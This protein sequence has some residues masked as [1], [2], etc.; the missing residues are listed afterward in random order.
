D[1]GADT[2][3]VNDRGQTALGA[4]VFRQSAASVNAL[5][6]AG[7]DPALGGPSAR[8]VATFF[9]LPEMVALLGSAG[10]SQAE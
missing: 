7:A 3:R 1:K 6:A 2:A 9:E 4:A 5:L 10:A 8:E